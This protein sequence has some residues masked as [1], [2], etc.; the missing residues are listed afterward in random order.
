MKNQN[1]LFLF[2]ALFFIF[3]LYILLLRLT[4]CIFWKKNSAYCW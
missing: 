1:L 3:V 2:I 4:F